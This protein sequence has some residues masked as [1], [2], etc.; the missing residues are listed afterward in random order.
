[1]ST[2]LLTAPDRLALN[3]AAWRNT[4]LHFAEPLR[5]KS[6][7]DPGTT[8]LVGEKVAVHQLLQSAPIALFS[9]RLT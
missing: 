1:L 7:L 6:V 2:S 8:P 5:L 9:T 4:T 3:P